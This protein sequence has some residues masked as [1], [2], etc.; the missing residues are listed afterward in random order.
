MFNTTGFDGDSVIYQ[1]QTQAA[2]KSEQHISA[3][4]KLQDF[5]RNFRKDGVYLYR[6]VFN[7]Y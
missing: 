4:Q 2:Q 7:I 5:I 6:Y 1:K 3:I